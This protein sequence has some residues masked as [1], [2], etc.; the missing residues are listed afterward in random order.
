[1]SLWLNPNKETGCFCG[2]ECGFTA[3]STFTF[4]KNCYLHFLLFLLWGLFLVWFFVC[5]FWL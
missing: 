5:L 2:L 4:T 1:M 3:T